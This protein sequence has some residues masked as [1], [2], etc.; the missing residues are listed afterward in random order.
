MSILYRVEG[1]IKSS[2]IDKRPGAG[3]SSLLSK[4]EK[5]VIVPRRGRR[6]GLLY[7]FRLVE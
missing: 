4:G 1:G 6:G 2:L 5:S 3:V 7:A